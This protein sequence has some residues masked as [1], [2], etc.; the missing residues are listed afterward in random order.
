MRRVGETGFGNVEGFAVWNERAS[1]RW[2]YC[3]GGIGAF[4]CSSGSRSGCPSVCI[5]SEVILIGTP[6]NRRIN[7]VL[8][9]TTVQ[10][11][12]RIAQPGQRNRFIEQATQHI[13][14]HESINTLRARLE[15]TAVPDRDLDRRN[16]RRLVGGRYPRRAE[17]YLT[18][19]DPAIGREIR[20]PRPA[21]V[22][23][24]DVS[25]RVSPHRHRRADYF[26]GPLPFESCACPACCRLAHGPVSY[27]STVDAEAMDRA[28]EAVRI[29]LGL[30]RL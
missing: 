23:Q 20:K 17:I 7:I 25:N 18:A 8:P 6:M 10:T 19:L 13:I 2:R 28:D 29:S 21:L 30:I 24:N 14:S 26:D 5:R 27:F 3:N 22:I 9:E 4:A 15:Q 1:A 16:R 11:I 12:D